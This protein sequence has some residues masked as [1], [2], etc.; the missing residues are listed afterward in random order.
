MFSSIRSKLIA[1]IIFLIG[2]PLLAVGYASYD[3]A[4]RAILAQTQEQLGNLAVKTA[5]QIDSFLDGTR[6]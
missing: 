3:T 2:L 1:I 6:R 5:Q 4:S